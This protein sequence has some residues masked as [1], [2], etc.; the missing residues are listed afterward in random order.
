MKYVLKPFA[1]LLLCV[2]MFACNKREIIPAPERQVELKNHFKGVI[3]GATTEF[4]ENVNGFKG[5]SNFDLVI[6]ASSMDSAI[7][8]S[9]FK[10]TSGNQGVII[11]HGSLAFDYGASD[12]PTLASFESFYMNGA[13]HQPAFSERGL[14]GFSFTYIDGNGNVWESNSVNQPPMEHVEYLTMATES[15]KSGTYAKFKVKFAT[16][17]YRTYT[18]PLTLLPVTLTLDVTDAVY[19]GWYKR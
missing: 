14:N 1:F 4:T 17:V 5:E 6:N 16:R 12:R 8:H 11:K 9:V 18:D 10:S 15:D 2:T 7:Y 19:T 3:N 13:N